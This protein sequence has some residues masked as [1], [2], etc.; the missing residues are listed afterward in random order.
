MGRQGGKTDASNIRPVGLPGYLSSQR[1]SRFFAAGFGD[2]FHPSSQGFIYSGLKPK[3]LV[4]HVQVTRSDHKLSLEMQGKGTSR[5]LLVFPMNERGPTARAT[6]E[7][8]ELWL[9]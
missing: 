7:R 2:R 3:P 9:P 5:A 8:R 1:G 4:V 6:I